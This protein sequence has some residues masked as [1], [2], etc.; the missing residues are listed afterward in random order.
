MQGATLAQRH[1]QQA[2]L[3]RIGGLA[4][5]FRHLAR[6]AVAEPDP[7]LLVADHHQRCEAEATAALHDLR[8]AIDVHEL[9]DEFAVALFPLP[10]AS[11]TCHVVN[12]VSVWA[13][14]P[15]CWKLSPPSRAASASALTRP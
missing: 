12:S 3:G 13:R 2:A 14:C 9:V 1:A 11:R 5:R 6:L 10:I 7:A 15:D 8:H 4:D